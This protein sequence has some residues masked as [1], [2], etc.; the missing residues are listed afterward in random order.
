MINKASLILAL[1]LITCMVSCEKD[2]IED[3]RCAI[4]SGGVIGGWEEPKDS[5]VNQKPDTTSIII[6]VTQWGDTIVHEIKM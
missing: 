4:P 3:E 6:E 2:Y 1:S 5:T